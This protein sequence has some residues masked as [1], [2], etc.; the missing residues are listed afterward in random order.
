MGNSAVGKD[1]VYQKLLLRFPMLHPLVPYTTRPQRQGE[2]EGREYHFVGEEQFL[3]LRE[4]GRM[5]EERAYRT[6]KGLWR[7]GSVAEEGEGNISQIGIGT[8]ESYQKFCA[9]FGR[10]CMIPLYLEVAAGERLLRGFR[11]EKKEAEPC[12]P[13]LVRRFQAD[14]AD[15]TEE[16]LSAAGIRKRYENLDLERCLGELYEVVLQYV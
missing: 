15:Y 10:E 7:Y 6:E 11:R 12:Y 8:L 13:E 5:I 9:Y 1:T 3:C 14:E 16:K 2:E 4:S